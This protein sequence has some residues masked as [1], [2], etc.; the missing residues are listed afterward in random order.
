MG[1]EGEKL[2]RIDRKLLARLGQ[3]ETYQMVRVP[4]TPPTWSTWKRYCEAVGVSMGRAIVTLIERE[5][6]V[7]DNDHADHADEQPVSTGEVQEQLA[8]RE[9]ELNA[10]EEELEAREAE[11]DAELDQIIAEAKRLG[12]RQAELRSLEHNLEI[13]SRNAVQPAPAV[14][15]V[16]RNERC[17]CGSGRK[18]KQCH[19]R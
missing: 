1:L 4:V 17:P 5:L 16:G 11:L 12:T 15:Q 9:A 19:G 2:E 6:G 8:A 13:R 3:D 10:R 18:Y 7:F 14:P